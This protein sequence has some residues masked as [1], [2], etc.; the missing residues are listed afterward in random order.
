MFVTG[1]WPSSGEEETAEA[2]KLENLPSC[3][4]EE[5]LSGLEKDLQEGINYIQDAISEED[6]FNKVVTAPWGYEGRICDAVV[7]TRDHFLNHK[8]QMFL[9]LKLLGLPVN[10]TTL[11]GG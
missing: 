5:A 1:E 11:Y 7:L 3:T 6:F 2:M 8:M 10:T 9:Y 4:K